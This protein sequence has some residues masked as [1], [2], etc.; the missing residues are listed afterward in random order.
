MDPIIIL[1]QINRYL[2][3]AAQV[4]QLHFSTVMHSSSG[5]ILHKDVLFY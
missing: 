2:G 3:Q 4:K 1:L 5:C